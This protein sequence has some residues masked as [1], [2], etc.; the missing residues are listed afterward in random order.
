MK[1]SVYSPSAA[2]RWMRCPASVFVEAGEP[3]ESSPFA[4]LGTQAH[5]LAAEYLVTSGGVYT[6]DD[7]MMDAVRFYA[8]TVN[9]M[10]GENG[11]RHVET[12]VDFSQALGVQNA[13]GTSDC[14]IVDGE[15]LTVLDFKYGT[16]VKVEARD[17]EQMQLYAL[18][19]LDTLG[20]RGK[21]E[22]VLL[23]IIQPRIG[24]LSTWMIP[25]GKLE[26]FEARARVA[27]DQVSQILARGQVVNQDFTP[28]EKQCRFCRF[29][30]KCQ[31][32][33]EHVYRAVVEDFQ[34]LETTEVLS[35][36]RDVQAMTARTVGELMAEVDL[37][38]A[39]CK[40]LR[41]RCERDLHAGIDIPG[42]KLVEGRKGYRKW[43]DPYLAAAKL[44]GWGLNDNQI[45]EQSLISP[46]QVEKLMKAGALSKE[47]FARLEA[48]I[49]RPDGK[50]TVAPTSD[51]RPGI[52][53]VDLFQTQN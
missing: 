32:L 4:E 50:P 43:S 44:R 31:P 15:N 33:A 47:Q 18:G 36:A 52:S 53:Q 49:S 51:R 40:D 8:G 23:G 26:E 10:A 45:Y 12:R 16:G 39:W 21:I 28:G 37:I 13:F 22:N 2:H 14:I 35:N 41:A 42:W 27:A 9:A 19:A 25:I 46:A 34:D 24:N 29:K 5:E 11:H 3:N 1:H 48:S 17:N 38:E 7:E 20:L 30:S 6:T